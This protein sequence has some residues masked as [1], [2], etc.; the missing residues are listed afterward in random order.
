MKNFLGFIPLLTLTFLFS[1]CTSSFRIPGE[2]NI[3][4]KNLSNEYYAIAEAYMDVKKYDK[5]AEYYELAMRNKALYLTSYYKL[6]RSYALAKNWEKAKEAYTYLLSLDPENIMLKS[7]LAYITAMGGDIDKAILDYKMLIELNPYDETLL[8][9][10]VAL[11]INVGRGEDAEDSFFLLKEKFPDNKQITT[12][13]QQLSDIV[14]NFDAE[15][16]L[17]PPESKQEGAEN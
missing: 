15:K 2:T 14:D 13:A 10:Y 5:A 7:S 17:P 11:L 16:K 9:G 4:L 1:S 8:E 6:A 3:I 12:F